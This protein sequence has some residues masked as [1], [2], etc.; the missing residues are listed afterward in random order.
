VATFLLTWNPDR[1]HWPEDEF[2]AA[3]EATAAGRSVSDKWSVGVQK[4][5]ISAG[6][7]AFLVRQR[8]DR[9]IVASGTFTSGIFEDPHW[10]GT[11]RLTRYAALD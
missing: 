7:R 4:V 6:D 3:I 2:D 8:R 11:A 5:G 10:D 9:C 1:W